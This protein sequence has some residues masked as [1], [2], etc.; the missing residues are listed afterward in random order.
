MDPRVVSCNDTVAP[1]APEKEIDLRNLAITLSKRWKLI[2]GLTLGLWALTVIV[3]LLLPSKYTAETIVMPP[4]QN[5]SI[6]SALLGQLGSSSALAS[7]AGPSLG[8]KNP[9]DMYVSLF[10]TQPVEYPLIQH[11]GLMTRYHK[12]RMSDTARA[13]ESRSNVVLGSKDGLIH[14]TVTDR[15]PKMAAQ[16]ANEYVD[17]FRKLSAHLAIT[18]AGQRRAFFQQQ[19]LEANGDLAAAEESMKSMEEATGVL[20]I[21][22]QSR[23][24]V[25]SAAIL[26]EQINAK[27]VELQ[28]MSSYA[29]ENNPQIITTER[30]L[31][32]MK[33]QIAQLAGKQKN[34]SD[35]IVPKGNIPAAQ[36]EYVRK[37]RD[38]K[39]YET[40]VEILA[41]QFETAKLEE[42]EEGSI[43]QVV[44]DATPPD[45]RSFPKPVLFGAVGLALS[46]AIS[47]G[48]CIFLEGIKN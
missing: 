32:A 46:F 29:T 4:N 35:I 47:C 11:F 22:S 41:R 28:A 34:A 24:L 38:L 9:G 5:S 37:M 48:S 20:E 7:L 8:I 43:I 31:N 18:E 15:D 19:L 17:E 30:E 16:I 1:R 6:S 25:D 2:A 14:I 10:R 27:E 33:A 21:D 13:F 40:V 42:A 12:S 44:E 3:I 39:Y 45:K 36:M 26:R 23:A